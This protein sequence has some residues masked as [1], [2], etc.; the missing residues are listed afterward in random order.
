MLGST[1]AAPTLVSK[2]LTVFLYSSVDS[3]ISGDTPGAAPL[4]QLMV[5]PPGFVPTGTSPGPPPPTVL[6]LPPEPEPGG[7]PPPPE[8]QAKPSPHRTSGKTRI[9]NALR[10]VMA[11]PTSTYRHVVQAVQGLM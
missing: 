5:T 2:S 11:W 6:P 7:G 9:P 10:V 8:V 4:S 3:F 1:A